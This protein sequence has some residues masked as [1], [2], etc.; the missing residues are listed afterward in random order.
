VQSDYGQAYRELYQ[1][2]WWWRAREAWIV[3]VLR[4]LIPDSHHL[5]ILDIGC[6]DGL[7]FDSL[8]EFGEVEGLEPDASLVS[9][10]GPYRARIHVQ[11]FD[12]RFRVT[13]PYDLVL[14]LDVL[15][16]IPDPVAALMRAM[17]VLS[18]E[19]TFVATLPAFLGLWTNHDIINE[20][21][22]RFDK[23]SFADVAR[24]AGLRVDRS[25]Y[26]FHWTY[27]VKR[28]MHFAEPLIHSR[29]KPPQIPVSA[30]NKALYAFSRLEQNLLGRVSVPFGSSLLIVGGHASRSKT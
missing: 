29:P 3:A 25:S 27:P 8:A 24:A 16:H 9:P 23:R 17:A 20:H 1:R 12:E 6:G 18:P 21:I 19:G 26:F 11:P 13:K 22:T 15:E 28:L 2:H 10:D 30:L 5:S 14:M 4:R 7:F